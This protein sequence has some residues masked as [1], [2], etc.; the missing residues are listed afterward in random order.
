MYLPLAGVLF[1]DRLFLL[2]IYIRF[3]CDSVSCQHRGCHYHHYQRRR[4][5]YDHYH[6]ALTM[7]AH[8]FQKSLGNHLTI[9]RATMVTWSNFHYWGLCATIQNLLIE[10]K[11]VTNEMQHL[12]SS[13]YF[14]VLFLYMFR[15]H[16]APIIRSSKNCMYNHWYKS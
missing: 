13:L 8:I 16:F 10:Y 6:V 15:E 12:L 14:T 11:R 2:Y 7:S 9:R 1:T 3:C 5:C 4:H